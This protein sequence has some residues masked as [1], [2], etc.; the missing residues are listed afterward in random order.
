MTDTATTPNATIRRAA[1]AIG[2]AAAG[3]KSSAS[4]RWYVATAQGGYPQTIN[5][6]ATVTL[7][8]NT[9]EGPQHPQT[10]APYIASMDPKVAFAVAR[11]LNAVADADLAAAHAAA[12]QLAVDYLRETRRC[13]ACGKDVGV[14]ADGAL[15]YHGTMAATCPGEAAGAGPGADR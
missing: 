5:E 4:G 1:D 14:E 11:L 15:G 6:S 2:L 7:K 9:F 12:A 3:A 10:T 13:L 8:A